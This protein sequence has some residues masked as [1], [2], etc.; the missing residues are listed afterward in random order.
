MN[1]DIS[2]AKIFL[3]IPTGIPVLGD[4]FGNPSRQLGGYAHYYRSMHFFDKK[5]EGGKYR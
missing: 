2:G 3:K 4:S 1:F 5:S